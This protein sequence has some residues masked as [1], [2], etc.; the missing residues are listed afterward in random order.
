MIRVFIGDDRIAARKEI[1]RWMGTRD[2]EVIEG[3]ELQPED[4]PNI[5][6]GVSL[7]DKGER[8]ILLRD[9][10]KSPAGEFLAD[11]AD[12]KHKV[13]IM[14]TKLDKRL[15]AWKKLSKVAEVSEFMLKDMDTRKMF[16][17]F[18][19]AKTDGV[20]AIKTLEEIRAGLEPKA[21][22]GV[23]ASTALKDYQQRGGQRE[24]RV[25][26]EMAKLD[27]EIGEGQASNKSLEKPWLLIE[28]FLLRVSKM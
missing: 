7:F 13:A 8:K 10:L 5:F 16:D 20:R 23:M 12:T 3:E 19:I 28:G 27:M 21:F 25:L 2:Y 15:E 26:R 18:R 4:L 6:R 24:K 1:G 11:Y 17:V 9:V 22:I 14:E